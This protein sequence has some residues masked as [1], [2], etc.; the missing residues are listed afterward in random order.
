VIKKLIIWIGR[1]IGLALWE[2]YRLDE[3]RKS[4][5][6]AKAEYLSQKPETIIKFVTVQPPQPEN[7]PDYL[8]A[9]AQFVQNDFYI[10]FIDSKKSEYLAKF[11]AGKDAE[12]CRGAI[13]AIDDFIDEAQT[14]LKKIAM[15]EQARKEAHEQEQIEQ[16]E[17]AA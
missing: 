13:S 11:K 16:E 4:Y 5:E 17:N 3:L 7:V 8:R 12:F 14:A 10:H 1:K 15:M 6:V 2:D 9:V